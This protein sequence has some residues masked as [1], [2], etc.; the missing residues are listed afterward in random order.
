MAPTTYRLYLDHGP[1]RKTTMVHVIDLM[2]CIANAATTEEALEHGWE[3]LRELE[4][5]L[6]VD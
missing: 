4:R 5:R 6:G 3:H 2:G 1:K